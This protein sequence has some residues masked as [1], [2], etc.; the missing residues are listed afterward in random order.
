M[1]INAS[2]R[3]ETDK[4]FDGDESSVGFSNYFFLRLVAR[5]RAFTKVDF[6]YTIFDTCYIRD[7]RFDSCDFTGCRFIG[8]NLRG[9]KFSGCKFDYAIFERT[10][11]DA[12]ILDTE[13]PGH[14]NL[15]AAFA[16][17]LRTNYQQL[18]DADAANKAIRVE[19]QATE[20]HLY[21]AWSSNESYYRKH[22]K[23]LSRL[24]SFFEWLKFKALDFVWGN[25]ESAIRLCLSALFVLC[26]MAIFDVWNFGDPLRVG[27]YIKSFAN[28]LEIFLGVLAP[29]NYAKWYLATITLVRFISIG[30]FLSIFIKRFNRR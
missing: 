22:Y 19:L 13:C 21:K 12:D 20:V 14:E 7:C 29:D 24:I 26:L 30:F 8:T 28:A 16:R 15:K 11:V 25:G 4:K 17:T 9:S 3:L 27:S 18:G 2:K 23:G 5:R 1:L 6:R 10:S